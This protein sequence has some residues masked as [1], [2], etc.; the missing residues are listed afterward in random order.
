MIASAIVLRAVLP[1]G[2]CTV[3]IYNGPYAAIKVAYDHLC[4]DWLP[5]SDSEPAD[6]PP[7]EVYLNDPAETDEAEL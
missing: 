1:V 4:R 7:Y 2:P 5:K 3:M 6:L